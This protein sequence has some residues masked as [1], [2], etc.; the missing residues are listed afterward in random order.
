[1]GTTWL[2]YEL[3]FGTSWQGCRYNLTGKKPLM[4]RVMISLTLALGIALRKNY[5]IACV[6]GNHNHFG[7][8]S[9]R[10]F[11]KGPK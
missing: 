5:T 2:G 10:S 7:P 1:M 11:F 9:I 6:T 4:V 3:V 8:W